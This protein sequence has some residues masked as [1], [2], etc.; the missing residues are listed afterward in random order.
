MNQSESEVTIRV[1]DMAHDNITGKLQTDYDKSINKWNWVQ[2]TPHNTRSG[3]LI[4]MEKHG[5]EYNQQ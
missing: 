5:S 3:H 4:H 1:F 2:T